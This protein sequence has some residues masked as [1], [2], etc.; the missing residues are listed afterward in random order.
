VGYLKLTPNPT[1][2]PF[3]AAFDPARPGPAGGAGPTA[4]VR[5]AHVTKRDRRA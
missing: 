2:N 1:W 3:W 5:P 4:L